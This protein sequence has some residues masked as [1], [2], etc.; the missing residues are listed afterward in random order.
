MDYIASLITLTALILLGQKHKYAW[1]INV[2]AS[3]TWLV[4]ATRSGQ[5]A[6]ALTNTVFLC[7]SLHYWIEQCRNSDESQTKSLPDGKQK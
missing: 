7:V 4:Y 2:L 3:L 5:F 1:P 6:L